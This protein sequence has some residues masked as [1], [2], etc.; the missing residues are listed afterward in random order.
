MFYPILFVLLA[1]WSAKENKAGL[2]G[3]FFI[4]AVSSG[5]W[6]CV[7]NRLPW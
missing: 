6:V 2:F 7:L 3:F 4:L 1:L 5:F